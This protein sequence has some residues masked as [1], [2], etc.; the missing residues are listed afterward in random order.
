MNCNHFTDRYFPICFM[1]AKDHMKASLVGLITKIK[2]ISM[3]K[4]KVKIC[5]SC[6]CFLKFKCPAFLWKYISYSNIF[7]VIVLFITSLSSAQCFGYDFTSSTRKILLNT[8]QKA[9][10]FKNTELDLLK[11]RYSN[12]IKLSFSLCS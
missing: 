10:F 11:S 9:R 1:R 2:A 6:L 8:G 12:P 3:D 4:W 5:F 7:A